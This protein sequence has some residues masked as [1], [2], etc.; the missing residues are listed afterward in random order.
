MEDPHLQEQLED[1]D[2]LLHGLVEVTN[3]LW[4]LDSLTA[5]RV[6]SVN[7]DI[8]SLKALRVSLAREVYRQHQ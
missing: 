7:A 5:E 8:A 2:T 6:Q 3:T 1:I 4:N